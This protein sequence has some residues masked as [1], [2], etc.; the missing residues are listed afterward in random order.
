MT[1]LLLEAPELNEETIELVKENL[2]N[3]PQR[4]VPCVSTLRSLVTNR[5]AIRSLALQVL[6]D[7]C[8]NEND[9]MRRTG[10][11]A[12]KKYDQPDIHTKV[13][14]FSVKALNVLATPKDVEMNGEGGGDE[15]DKEWSSKDV[16]RHAELYFVSCNKRPSLL[17]EYV[18]I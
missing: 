2:Y 13:E 15:S 3:V 6:L 5:P 14:E 11:V 9:N 18:Y 1:K 17:K 16:L 12:V 7:I 8:T 4:F 10:L